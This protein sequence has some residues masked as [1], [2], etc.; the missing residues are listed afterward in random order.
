[1]VNPEPYRFLA[2][3]NVGG[4]SES[5]CCVDRNDHEEVPIG[6][7]YIDLVLNIFNFICKSGIQKQGMNKY[8]NRN[9]DNLT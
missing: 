7:T 6:R 1:M 4:I 5:K 8:T 2:N 3:F 9:H